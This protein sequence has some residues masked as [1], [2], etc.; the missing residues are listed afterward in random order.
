MSLT[1]DDLD[2]I[3]ARQTEPGRTVKSADGLITVEFDFDNPVVV[4]SVT[5]RDALIA[6]AREGLDARE[7]ASA[8]KRCGHTGLHVPQCHYCHHAPKNET[9]AWLA[10]GPDGTP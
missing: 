2:Q 7:Q 9:H 6:L 5:E 4:L 3:A 10:S 8:C 1:R